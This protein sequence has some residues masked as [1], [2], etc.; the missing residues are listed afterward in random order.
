MNNKIRDLHL[1]EICL[2]KTSLKKRILNVTEHL[3]KLYDE[4]F[5]LLIKSSFDEGV[6][7]FE[8][9]DH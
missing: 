2:K 8:F 1:K 6:E 3:I 4:S 7:R 5:L 9:H